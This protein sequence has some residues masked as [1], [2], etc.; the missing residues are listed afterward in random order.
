MT[1]LQWYVVS[2]TLLLYQRNR[3]CKCQPVAPLSS[4]HIIILY[5]CR[6]TMFLLTLFRVIDVY[7][8]EVVFFF[9]HYSKICT[10]QYVTSLN[11]AYSWEIGC[12]FHIS[13]RLSPPFQRQPAS[14]H[15]IVWGWGEG[16]H[17]QN[18]L[19]TFGGELHYLSVGR[20]AASYPLDEP[21]TAPTLMFCVGLTFSP[22][23]CL[24][25]NT[26]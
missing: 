12:R 2:D 16:V 14:L 23:Y 6:A 13:D 9:W 1:H 5:S 26:E 20:L 8:A 11:H 17:W 18:S 19:H 4:R 25:K 15:T 3:V 7:G 22:L 21:I 24:T 10:R